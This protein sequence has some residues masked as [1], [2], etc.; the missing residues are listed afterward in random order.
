MATEAPRIQLERLND[1]KVA[2]ITLNRA[3][4]RNALD[5]QMIDEYLAALESVRNDSGIRVV[6]TRAAGPSFC[7]GLDLHYLR[8]YLYA[9]PPGDFERSSAPRTLYNCIRHFPKVTIAQVHGYAVGG[10]YCVLASHDLAFAATNAQIGLPE[11]PRG[12][13][14]QFATSLLY[15]SGIPIKKAIMMHYTGYNI[16]GA[17]A[18]RIGLVSQ[19]FEEAKLEQETLRLAT[20]IATRH[21]GTIASAKISGQMGMDLSLSEAMKMD[22]LVGAWQQAMVDSVGHVDDYLRSQ[23]GGTKSN[24]RRPDA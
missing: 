17:E 3:E 12:S 2:R 24:Y 20:E 23:K 15:H 13:F 9:P 18:D 1:I 14:G 16:T 7:A 5:A 11:I 10:G 6:I 19:S 4:K 8:D 21:P 22:Q